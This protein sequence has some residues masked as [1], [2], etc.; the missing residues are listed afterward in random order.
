MGARRVGGGGMVPWP[1]PLANF[2]SIISHSNNG[3]NLLS[4][5]LAKLQLLDI[6]SENVFALFVVTASGVAAGGGGEGVEG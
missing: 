6:S 2:Q 3:C 1:T 4:L 5:I